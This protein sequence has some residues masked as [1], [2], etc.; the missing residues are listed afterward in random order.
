MNLSRYIG[1]TTP[2]QDF[3]NPLLCYLSTFPASLGRFLFL[4]ELPCP[5]RLI[6]RSACSPSQCQETAI[7]QDIET[8]LPSWSGDGQRD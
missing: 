5:I 8:L 1:R 3:I 7:E 6:R 4:T 2:L